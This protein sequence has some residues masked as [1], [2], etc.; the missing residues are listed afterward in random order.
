MVANRVD[1]KH[2]FDHRFVLMLGSVVKCG[3]V[4]ENIYTM[5]VKIKLTFHFHFFHINSFI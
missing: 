4:E 3:A 5:D 1:F 2:Q